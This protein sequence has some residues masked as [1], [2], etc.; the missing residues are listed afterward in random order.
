MFAQLL[1]PVALIILLLMV[2]Q[3]HVMSVPMV[4]MI[5]LSGLRVRSKWWS[6][7]GSSKKV[8]VQ[9]TEIVS[10]LLLKTIPI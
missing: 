4:S 10:T 5:F 2:L 8:F 1:V 9:E 6:I 7:S 3:P